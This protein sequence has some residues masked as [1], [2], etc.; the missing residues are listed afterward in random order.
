M[1]FTFEDLKG[2]YYT[3]ADDMT[4]QAQTLFKTVRR[5]TGLYICIQCRID[6]ICLVQS[7]RCI[8]LKLER[9]KDAET[10]NILKIQVL[11]PLR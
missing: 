8:T 4:V 7:S 3:N 11:K 1:R 5:T 2:L 9:Y 10:P 6:L